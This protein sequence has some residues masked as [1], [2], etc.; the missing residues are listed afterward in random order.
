M[1]TDQKFLDEIFEAI[2][3]GKLELTSWESDFIESIEGQTQFSSK[4]R[5][6]IDRIHEKIRAW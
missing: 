5:Q 3:D 6:V 1:E 2:E 4:Q